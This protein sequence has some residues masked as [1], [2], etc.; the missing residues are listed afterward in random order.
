MF[1]EY[2]Y[3]IY[4]QYIFYKLDDPKILDC[5]FPITNFGLE[6]K[7]LKSRD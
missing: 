7:A 3:T 5:I 1:C 4:T 6:S 2:I